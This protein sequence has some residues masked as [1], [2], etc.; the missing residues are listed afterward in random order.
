MLQTSPKRR[1]DGSG[2]T[3]ATLASLWPYIWPQGRSDL[4][5]RV[6]IAMVLLVVSKVLTVLVPYAYKWAVDALEGGAGFA[7]GVP[8][9]L[10][11]AAVPAFLV[12]AYGVGRFLAFGFQQVRDAIFARVGQHA[13]RTLGYRTF[14]HLHRLSLR[15]HL[16]RRTG[17]LSRIIER[18]VKGIEIIVRFTLLQTIPTILE[19]VL[20]AFVIAFQFGVIYL[21]TLVVMMVLYLWFTVKAT[22]WRMSIR[23]AARLWGWSGRTASTA[24]STA[25]C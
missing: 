22:E 4:K 21:V 2:N 5:Q 20:V 11:L 23:R 19:F 9:W 8:D 13:V 10:K 12:I 14:E 1:F 15:F 6:V 18:G 17:G 25:T 16:E 7:V 3:F 24:R